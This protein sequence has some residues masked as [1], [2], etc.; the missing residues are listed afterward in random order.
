M[1]NALR[2]LFG[3]SKEPAP[4]DEE[5][6]EEER[7]ARLKREQEKNPTNFKAGANFAAEALRRRKKAMD[8]EEE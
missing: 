6:T 4:Q 8:M 2:S 1:G 3:M 7:L 5:E